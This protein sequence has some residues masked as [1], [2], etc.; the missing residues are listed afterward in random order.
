MI[1]SLLGYRSK[2][3]HQQQARRP[4]H[5]RSRDGGTRSY[6]NARGVFVADEMSAL[7]TEF[8][9]A[10]HASLQGIAS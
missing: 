4:D 8:E 9:R 5:H 6:A 3:T 10:I 1:H 7:Y 2:D